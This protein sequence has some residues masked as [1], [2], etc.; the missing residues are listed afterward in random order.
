MKSGTIALVGAL[1]FL[2]SGPLL[3]QEKEE[4]DKPGPMHKLLA[5]RAGDYT[6][7]SKF[8]I[9]PGGEPIESKGASKIRAVLGGRFVLQENTGTMLGKPFK[10]LHLEGYNNLTKKFEATWAYT[11][12]TGMMSLVGT[13]KDDGKT[14]H[15]SGSFVND[16]G[17]KQ[18]LH[19]ETRIVDDDTFVVEL[20]DKKTDGTKGPKMETTYS[21]KK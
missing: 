9:K 3:S 4:I 14:I 19:V 11:R 13:S 17:E 2:S 18:T 10:S 16:K 15:Y 20:V 21:R 5:K 1:L 7:T 6:T 12:A 8:W